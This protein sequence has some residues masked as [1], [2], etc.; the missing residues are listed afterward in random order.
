[1][2]EAKNAETQE[3]IELAGRL[4]ARCHLLAV[5]PPPPALGMAAGPSKAEKFRQCD[6]AAWRSLPRHKW[7]SLRWPSGRECSKTPKQLPS[8]PVRAVLHAPCRHDVLTIPPEVTYGLTQNGNALGDALNALEAVARRWDS[9]SA[10]APD[11]N[12]LI[13]PTSTT[14]SRTPGR[15]PADRIVRLRQLPNQAAPRPRDAARSL[16]IDLRTAGASTVSINALIYG[17][18]SA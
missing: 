5:V 6:R 1:M 13:L 3:G 15:P 4:N 17:Q 11:Q 8:P 10:I 18:R 12:A 9:R 7:G 2:T 14:C 16:L